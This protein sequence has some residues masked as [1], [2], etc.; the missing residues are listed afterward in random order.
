MRTCTFVLSAIDE[1][2]DTLLPDIKDEFHRRTLEVRDAYLSPALSARRRRAMRMA[3]RSPARM[4]DSLEQGGTMVE[5]VNTDGGHQKEMTRFQNN[6]TRRTLIFGKGGSPGGN[7]ADRSSS[8]ASLSHRQTSV[9]STHYMLQFERDRASCIH[10]CLCMCC[11]LNSSVKRRVHR[12]LLACRA[13]VLYT[14]S[15]Y[16]RSIWW[17][18]KNPRWLALTLVGMIPYI[19]QL[20]WLLVFFL[21]NK[22]DEYQL[23]DF[24]TGF[25]MAR[26]VGQGCGFLLYGCAKYYFCVGR[27]PTYGA[28]AC[29]TYGPSLSVYGV[30]FHAA[31]SH[32]L[33]RFL[34]VAMVEKT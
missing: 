2:V 22:R 15:P 31:N 30:C 1:T 16:D 32:C 5:M 29:V 12:I 21:K 20:F 6:Q 14:L 28:E 3:R 17:S 8:V 27:L 25:Q 18:I 7:A 23:I 11:T 9:D 34:H 24:I 19:G 13:S 10:S 26:F 33:G 4:R